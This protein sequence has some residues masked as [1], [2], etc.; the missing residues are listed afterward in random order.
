MKNFK[1]KFESYLKSKE[2]KLTRPRKIIL[3]TVVDTDEH[4]DAESIYDQ[5]KEKHKGVS[6]A[7]V[8]RTIPL[9]I[10]AGLIRH[11]M[12][13]NFTDMYELVYGQPRHFHFIC[14]ECGKVIEEDVA[15]IESDFKK[16][17]VLH[18]F[19]VRDF[20]VNIYGICENCR[21]R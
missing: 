4:F 10:D 12:R 1:D 3:E 7:T 9:L 6:K 20:L 16:L 21:H 19:Q 2:L 17:A 11:A 13:E 5:I 15:E 8:Y 14:S 18:N